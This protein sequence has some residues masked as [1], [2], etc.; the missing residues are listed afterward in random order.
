VAGEVAVRASSAGHLLFKVDRY[1]S[2][3]LTR[4]WVSEERRK[5]S[6]ESYQPRAQEPCEE[7]TFRSAIATRPSGRV[8]SGRVSSSQASG[9]RSVI[10]SPRGHDDKS[11]RAKSLGQEDQLFRQRLAFL[12]HDPLIEDRPGPFQGEGPGGL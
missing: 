9:S 10:V 3:R 8:R 6:K 1:R 11:A 5:R 7:L 4:C 2:E 12:R